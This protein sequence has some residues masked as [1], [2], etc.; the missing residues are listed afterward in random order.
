MILKS[1]ERDDFSLYGRF[2]LSFDGITPPKL[3]EYNAD[4]PTALVEG[5]PFAQWFWLQETHPEADQ[6]NSIHERLI[7][8]WKRWAG[9]TIH[10]SGIKE[11]DEDAMTRSVFA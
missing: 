4:T 9:K 2:D 3:L 10:F 5:R 1:W 11:H 7:E 8:A 6:F